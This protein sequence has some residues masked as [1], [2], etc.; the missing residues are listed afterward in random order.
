MRGTATDARFW[1]RKGAVVYGVGI[2][3]DATAFSAMAS[4]FHGDDERLSKNSVSMRT[5]R[6]S[7][8]LEADLSLT[9]SLRINSWSRS[10]T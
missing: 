7:W 3:D 4:L 5:E 8:P 2:Y 6:S 1:R 10:I 9:H